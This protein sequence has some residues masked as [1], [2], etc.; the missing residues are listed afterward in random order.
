[1]RLDSPLVRLPLRVDPAR[2]AGEVAQ[3]ANADWRPHPLPHEGSS[4]LPLISRHGD[5]TDD[6]TTGPMRPT[7]LLDR[8]PYLRQLLAAFES[9]IGRARLIRTTN[10]VDT[11]PQPDTSHYSAHRVRLFVPVAGMPELRLVC[12]GGTLTP[13]LSEVW[14]IDTWQP[15]AVVRTTGVGTY[16]T[17]DT[18]G[19]TELWDRI[20]DGERPFA[21]PPVAAA[22]PDHLITYDPAVDPLLLTEQPNASPV[23]SPWEIE[24]LLADLFSDLAD[25]DT[26]ARF[27]DHL[28]RFLRGWRNLWAAHGA[29]PSGW[30]NFRTLL[31]E[32]DASLAPFAGT[33]SLANGVDAVEGVRQ[34][35]VRVAVNLEPA[36]T[37]E[38]R[39]TVPAQ[40]AP[41]ADP[42]AKP[43]RRDPSKEP[44][45]SVFTNGLPKL[46]AELG[47][48]LLVSTYQ[49]GKLVVVREQDGKLNTHFR[50]MH[51]PMGLAVADNRLA[52]GTKNHV[53]EFHDQPQVAPK[54][55]PVGTH[56]ACFLPRMV[57]TTGDIRVHEIGWAGDE[58]WLVNT[59]FSCL[60]TLDRQYSFV[61]RWRPKFVSALAPE[62]RCHLNGLCITGNPPRPKY[63]TCLGE[64][65]TAGGWR[66]N[67]RDG[68]M[69]IDVDTHEVLV[70][71]LSMP[72]SPRMHDGKLWVLES[73]VG[74]I[75]YLDPSTGKVV[76]VANL[77]GFTRGIDFVGPLAFVGLSQVRETAAFSGL[78]ITELPVE[79]RQCGVWVV[80][81]RNGQTI[82]FLRF[83]EGVQE[84][85]AVHA[86]TGIRFPDVLTDDDEWLANSFVLPD[87]ALKD[88]V[89]GT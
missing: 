68:G 33:L 58:L 77:P 22:R 17:F 73:G 72:H 20:T 87:D 60:C 24:C 39:T 42:A 79:E 8:V 52:V 85:F 43:D 14:A 5:P 40:V 11:H 2:L 3:F 59:R 15:H 13:K 1:M 27:R 81:I 53:W 49:A 83:E 38:R 86:L 41:T 64:T 69:L 61:P 35:V 7:P 63:V 21:D 50:G 46:F 67:K 70:R 66:A 28:W 56:D 84:I 44:L 34:A 30:E 82:G 16:L 47:I 48:S 75:G 12:G 51:G 23:M 62:D 10:D 9:V 29:D 55:D 65:D 32:L 76:Q 36:E 26:S 78:P 57:H 88:V 4:S 37:G 89:Q 6:T 19:S 71:G 18:V 80:D 31:G 45:R 74:G 25:T 54:L